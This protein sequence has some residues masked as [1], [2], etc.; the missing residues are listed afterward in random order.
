MRIAMWIRDQDVD[1]RIHNDLTTV[2]VNVMQSDLINLSVDHNPNH[3]S[4]QAGLAPGEI[5][6]E[7]TDEDEKED[8]EDGDAE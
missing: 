4:E 8:E 1:V 6:V 2:S 5:P 3:V 7:L